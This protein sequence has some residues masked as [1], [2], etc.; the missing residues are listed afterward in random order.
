MNRAV[1][2]LCAACLVLAPVPPLLGLAGALLL[3]ATVVAAAGRP[4]DLRWEPIAVLTVLNMVYW[5]LNALLVAERPLGG[6]VS[7]PFVRW[8]GRGVLCY[9]PLLCLALRARRFPVSLKRLL[10]T[11]VIVFALVAA[12]GVAQMA[13]GIRPQLANDLQPSAWPVRH[14]HGELWF[15]GLHRSHSAAGAAFASAGLAAWLLLLLRPVQK[16]KWLLPCFALIAWAL[17]FTKSRTYICAFLFAAFVA[18]VAVVFARRRALVGQAGKG[19]AFALT[20][21]VCLVLVPGGYSRYASMLGLPAR[22]RAYPARPATAGPTEPGEP[23]RVTKR[24]AGPSPQRKPEMGEVTAMNRKTY[25]SAGLKMAA[26]NPLLGVG[27]G[28]YGQVF[29]ELGYRT[30][31]KPRLAMMHAHNSFLHY[32]AELGL[33]GVALQAALWGAVVVCL[34][35][36]A[37]ASL[38]R[39]GKRHEFAL[40]AFG[41]VFMHL[42]AS[43][44]THVLWSPAAMLPV[45]AA[46][47]L[48]LRA[49]TA[50]RPEARAQEAF[51]T[52]N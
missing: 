34:A 31:W 49:A 21:L 42:V 22:F 27:L 35:P 8:Q 45:T 2:L 5:G 39:N 14:M 30:P 9:V 50:S 52:R 12:A 48:T 11:Y 16:W 28:R 15:F 19:V 43:M 51:G 25:W 1:W 37:W 20:V 10:N 46:V 32:M 4:A 47:A 33:V 36:P 38:R 29:Y 6:V 24:P 41:L 7:W 17:L 3:A 40:V 44:V 26:P 23:K 13:L 18:W